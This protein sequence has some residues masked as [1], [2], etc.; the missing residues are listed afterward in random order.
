MEKSK[1]DLDFDKS[2]RDASLFKIIKSKLY[3]QTSN[4]AYEDDFGRC[5]EVLQEHRNKHKKNIR[6]GFTGI[7][8]SAF[9][10]ASVIK[11]RTDITS[12]TQGG[13]SLISDIVR[14]DQY[15]EGL[16]ESTWMTESGVRILSGLEGDI[17]IPKIS[18]KPGFSW[19]AENANF[20]EQDAS[21]DDVT[22][23]PKYAGAIQV[24]S[25]GIF[26]RA[27]GNSIVR[28]VQE[29]LMRSFRSGLEKSFIQ[30]DG[31]SNKP[32]GIANIVE[33]GN[34][35]N[36]SKQPDGSAVDANT[37]GNPR[38]D[39][40]LDVEGKITSTNQMMPLLWLLNDKTRLAALQVL[41]FS[42]NGASQLFMPGSNMFADRRAIITNAVPSN[43]T[44][45]NKS[46]KS[47]AYLFQPQSLVLGRWLGGIQLQVNTQ[48]SEYWKA[49]KTAVRVI[50]CCNLASRR[51]SDF[52]K[53]GQLEV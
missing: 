29:E 18:T 33:A 28:F 8:E 50:D 23:S 36:A 19:I 32:K 22:L 53:Y 46:D 51:D 40:A 47:E 26:L 35:V 12:T 31:T 16:Y 25:L 2:K 1:E 42:V 13:D 3:E 14:P 45:G 49:G 6:D 20:P 21:F 38:Y 24:F 5:E 30:D 7:P 17:K 27:A 4:R 9:H 10:A 34:I 44:K 43:I 48:G 52:A 37:G 39:E 11:K 41:K 15:V